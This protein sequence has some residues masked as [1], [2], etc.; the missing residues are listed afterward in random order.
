M[1]LT[2]L[3]AQF[4]TRIMVMVYVCGLMV[5][6]NIA[7]A[8]AGQSS[9]NKGA[10]QMPNI[11]VKAEAALEDAM[12]AAPYGSNKVQY[13]SKGLNEVQGT[14]DYDKMQSG[15]NGDTPPAVLELEKSLGKVGDK[16][17]SAKDD[18]QDSV[19]SVL[20]QAGDTASRLKDQAG[21]ALKS[22]AGK[23]GDT[24]KSIKAKSKF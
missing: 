12:E 1:K 14:A 7:P 22:M 24:A 4:L 21:D 19:G 16:I 18:T 3:L 17:N 20:E 10:Q 6:I 11:Q 8:I 5:F 9:L 2:Q 23:A 13:E 15:A